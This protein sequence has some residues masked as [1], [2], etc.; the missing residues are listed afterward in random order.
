MQRRDQSVVDPR[1]SGLQ[2]QEENLP[3]L[4]DFFLQCRERLASGSA[5]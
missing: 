1:L 2:E 5:L 3:S 4:S